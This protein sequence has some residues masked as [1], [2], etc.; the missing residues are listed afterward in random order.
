MVLT[1][2]VFEFRAIFCLRVL[3]F[4]LAKINKNK[5]IN[6]TFR[7]LLQWSFVYNYITAND[8]FIQVS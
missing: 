4:A 7:N 2:R 1:V 6:H 3:N 5:V 8:P